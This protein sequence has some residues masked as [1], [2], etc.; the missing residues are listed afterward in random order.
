MRRH[1]PREAG[2][3][4]RNT[5]SG[6]GG[7]NRLFSRGGPPPSALRSHAQERPRPGLPSRDA[8]NHPYAPFHSS[9]T[10][11]PGPAPESANSGVQRPRQLRRVRLPL[12]SESPGSAPCASPRPSAGTL[13]PNSPR[14]GGGGGAQAS[15]RAPAARALR[16]VAVRIRLGARSRPGLQR[17]RDPPAAAS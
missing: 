16:Q 3:D 6:G 8:R 14:R 12:F 4:T 7:N 13:D 5:G 15:G 1:Q 11:E 2:P 17:G 10:G 9:Q